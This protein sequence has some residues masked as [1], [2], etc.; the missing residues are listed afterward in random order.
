MAHK[1]PTVKDKILILWDYDADR[2]I[3]ELDITYS[4]DWQHWLNW[5]ESKAT[6]SF[7]YVSEVGTFTAVKESRKQ[8]RKRFW[9]AHRRVDGKLRRTYLGMSENLTRDNLREAATKLSRRD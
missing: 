4:D 6:K 9:Y 3:L 2:L 7:R 1:T 5:L 8:G